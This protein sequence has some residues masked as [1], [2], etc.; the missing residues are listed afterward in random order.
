MLTGNPFLRTYDPKSL[1][2][3][4]IGWNCLGGAQPTRTP[5]LPSN[6]CPNGLRG[7]VR[8]PSCWGAFPFAGAE[9]RG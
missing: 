4:A 7:E 8:F 6:N 3:Q 5:Y 9:G 2:V 1:E